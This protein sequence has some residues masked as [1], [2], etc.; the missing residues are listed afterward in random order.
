MYVFSLRIPGKLVTLFGL[1][2][3]LALS[4]CSRNK[5]RIIRE[6]VAERVSDFRKKEL[7]KC[8]AVM[9]VDAEKMVDSLLL[10]EALREVNDSLRQKRPFRP[11]PPVAI[12]PIDS[13]AVK[14]IFDD[15][16]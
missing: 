2:A 16:K 11:L 9:L 6:K 10:Y 1:S 4:A 14:P 5:E 8:R 7:A 15:G 13:S 3:M 12:P